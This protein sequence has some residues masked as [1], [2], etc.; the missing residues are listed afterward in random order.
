MHVS[1]KISAPDLEQQS[2][3]SPV[4]GDKRPI[5]V[6]GSHRSGST[7]VGRMLA[8]APAVFYIHEP[9]NVTDPP[10]RGICSARFRYWFTYITAENEVAY[11][12]P[13]Q[14]MV[15][16]RYDW[17]AALREVRSFAELG[18]VKNQFQ[19][20]RQV[21]RQ[22]PRPLLKDPLAFFSTEWLAARFDM[23]VVIVMRHPAAF[24][25]S[26]KK[27]NWAHP[28]DHFLAQPALMQDVLYPFEAEVRAHA[29]Q[30]HTL[31]D[32]AILLWKIF[33]HTILHYRR[34]HPEWIFIRHE[35]LSREPAHGFQSLY[36]QLG[37][38]FSPQIQQVIDRFSSPLHP[39]E[40]EISVGSDQALQRDSQS[41]IWNWK[42]RL[43]VAEIR[44][45]RRE[46]DEIASAL[47]A[48]EDW[49]G[50]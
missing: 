12:Q 9:F 27:L 18:E 43:S 31:I 20:I 26:V 40:P 17:A 39:S 44:K 32:Q 16:L 45:I 7:W 4:A 6:T 37:L 19:E 23:A 41:N 35:D 38:V 14:N 46:T 1:S 34:L 3:G 22:K 42:N 33:H 10:G 2:I 36:N 25:S 49:G 47:Y 21:R 5:L 8:E 11:E 30:P 24:V 28:F 48:D 50:F 13:I 15:N 29:E